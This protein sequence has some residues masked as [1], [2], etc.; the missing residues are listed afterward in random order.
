MTD[1]KEEVV[2]TESTGCVI[3]GGGPAGC[4]LALLLARGGVPVTLLESHADF[5]RDF[6][7][8]TIHPSTL[9][10]MDTL[11]LGERLHALPH[12]KIRVMRIRSADGDVTLA[13]LARLRTKFPYVMTLPQARFLEILAADAARFPNFRLVMQANVQRLVEENGQV[14]GIRYRDG[15]NRFHE[16]RAPLTVA[17]DGRFS[18]L[19]HLA[20]IE[21]AGTAPPMDVLWFRLSKRESDPEAAAEIYVGGGRMAVILDR[22]DQWQIGFVISKGTY[23]SVRSGGIEPLRN[24]MKRL[25]PWLADRV[26][27]LTDW[28]QT[29][30]LNVESSRAS[31]W[32]KPGLLLIGDA[33]HVM[34]P[35]GG[36]GINVAIQD[37]IAAANR[38]TEPLRAGKLNEADLAAVQG[39]REF[40]V[41]A[42]Q[43]LQRVMQNR[44]AAPGLSG[45][46]FKLPWFMRLALSIPGLR[47]VPGRMMAFGPRRVRWR[48][49]L[50]RH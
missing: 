34:S 50:G 26:G 3:V 12:G 10:L 42:V 18:K 14:V 41:K 9:E 32:H 35:V 24:D 13:D 36:V 22:G 40:A 8:D 21:S 43:R 1:A 45:K 4:V 38:L 6:R 27:E 23:G 11:G 29:T 31:T 2:S 19:R 30:V 17:A 44:I 5:D 39:E 33:A 16:I 25:I 37:A 47:N 48:E 7:G 46:P 20:R 15:E 28:K 49:E